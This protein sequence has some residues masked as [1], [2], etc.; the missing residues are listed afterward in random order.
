MPLDSLA[1]CG[2]WKLS[3]GEETSREMA[4]PLETGPATHDI[5][6]SQ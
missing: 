5:I 1:A 2:V 3:S 6:H 4:L